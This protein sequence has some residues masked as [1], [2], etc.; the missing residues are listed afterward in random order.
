DD[1]IRVREIRVIENVECLGT[2][3]QI[4]SFIDSDLLEQRS[5]ERI[6]ARA[7][8]RSTSHVP[9]GPLTRQ[10]KGPRIVPLIRF[11]HDHIS[12]KVRIP[13]R[14]VGLIVV[15]GSGSI[16]AG[17]RSEGK[18]ALSSD[19]PIPLPAADQFVYN[20]S[21]AA[22]EALSIPKRQLITEVTI[23]LVRE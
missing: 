15:A 21:G 7:T 4:Q 16:G 17:Q 18:S 14:H 3:L 23:E 10:H 22:S 2:E 12:G 9:E 6:Q 11:P 5:I 19:D 8:E 20:T 1:L 13:V